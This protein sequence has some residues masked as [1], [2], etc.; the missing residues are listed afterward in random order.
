VEEDERKKYGR[1][2]D[3][4][5]KKSLRMVSRLEKTT[6]ATEEGASYL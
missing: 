3:R 2:G 4:Y 1:G 5:R 6:T